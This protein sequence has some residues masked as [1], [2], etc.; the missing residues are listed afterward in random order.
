MKLQLPGVGM[1]TIKTAVSVMLSYLIFE[2]WQ[3]GYRAELDHL[4]CEA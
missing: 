4:L 3:R 1:R 2:V